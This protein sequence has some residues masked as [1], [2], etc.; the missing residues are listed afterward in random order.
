MKTRILDLIDFEKVDTLLEGFNQS[1]GFVT[2]ILDL[3]GNVLSKS[4]WR[5]VC[6][7]FHRIHPETA[8]RCTISDTVLAGQMTTD[9]KYHFYKCLNGLVDVAVPIVIKGEHIANLFSGQFFFEEPNLQFFREQA[10]K[11]G[12]DEEIYVDAMLKVP[13]IAEEKVKV[14]MEFLLN[15]TQLISEMTFNKIKQ[16]ELNEQL[17]KSEERYRLVLENSLDAILLTSPD[18]KILSAN[19][20]AC[21]I[22]QRTEEEICSLSREGIVDYTDPRLPHLLEE[23]NRTGKAKGE[24]FMLRKD[25]TKFPV[26]LSTS[27]FN[28]QNGVLLTSMI[29]RDISERYKSEI[30]LKL[31]EEKF[32][33]AFHNSPDA[34][35]I[36][37]VS[38]GKIID[39]NETFLKLSGYER[40]FAIGNSTLLLNLWNSPND[41]KTYITLLKKQR[42]VKD[43]ESKFITSSGEVRDFLVSG[44]FFTINGENCIL[45]IL[46]DITEQKLAEET[47][48][49]NEQ[50]LRLFV[51]HSPAAIAMFDRDMRYIVASRRYLSDYDL[52][53]RDIIGRS[54]YDIFPEMP[55]EWKNIHQHCLKGAIEKSDN[56]PFPRASGK[57]DWIRWEIHPWFEKNDEI[58][59][60]IL[61]SEVITESKLSENKLKETHQ[62]LVNILENMTDGFVS[63]DND[64]NYTYMNKYAGEI[65]GRVPEEMIGKHIWTEFPEGIGQPFHLAY[66]KAKSEKIPIQFHEYYPPYKKWFENRIYPS[67]D[68]I[69]VF[70]QDI[71]E[72]KLAQDKLKDSQTYNRMLFEQSPIGLAL[73]N[74]DGKLIDVNP[75][76]AAIMGRTVDQCKQL[77]YWEITPEKYAP[78][79]KKQL[80]TLAKTGIYG[81]YEKEYIHKNGHLVPVRLQGLIF[82]RNGEKY[83]WS[84]VEDITEIKK[85]NEALIENRQIIKDERDFSNALLDGLPGILYFYDSNLNFQRWNKNFEKISG[86]SSE[87]IAQMSPMDLFSDDEKDLLK[88]KISTVFSEGYADVEAHFLTKNGNRILYFFTGL[89]INFNNKDC[90]IG[91]GIDISSLKHAEEEIKKLNAE[92]EFKVDLRTAQLE[93]SNK[94]LEAF[95]YSVSHDLR[96]PLRHINGYVNLLNDRFKDELPEKA[97]HYLETVT[98]AA[99]QMGMLIDDL[100]QFSRTGRQEVHQTITDMNVLINEALE[101]IKPDIENRKINW[102]IQ[103]LPEVFG[104]YALLKQ[105][106]INLIDNAVK[107]TRNEAF[108]EISVGCTENQENFVF[109]VRDNGVGFDM[110]YAHKLFGVFQRL[111]AQSEFEGTGIGLANVQRIIHKHNG[112][113]WAEAEPKI[114]ATFFFSLPKNKGDL[115]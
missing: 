94:E 38:D 36:T 84:S 91:V 68:G 92:L 35:T 1:T 55:E 28:D 64:W 31:S 75:K 5:Q 53:E 70:F 22:F 25:G 111:H 33:K 54:H 115:I 114:G 82:E 101:K 48:H 34:I 41:R 17:K 99:T 69:S 49:R 32:N 2:A 50:V 113:V 11:Y 6:T 74:M 76:Y 106:W 109:F 65:F 110:K 42:S 13:V 37:R 52:G 47:I 89:K 107:Y 98:N 46:R 66:E 15:M 10:K 83:I 3:E 102:K 40:D 87:E 4:G 57:L 79:E 71:T 58:G 18:G 19:R 43:F 30:A 51:E 78:M 112:Q 95:S 27:V 96:A 45:G 104:D 73:A 7:E 29:I 44:E 61:F 86:Y 67:N 93:A 108:A 26:E 9:K 14:A 72:I 16:S 62:K 100:L 24:L 90:L 12:F 105:V 60:V 39:V 63:L 56:D 59:G 81:P 88:D 23:R 85:S 21:S 80:E 97:R 103:E 77:T 20:A 8:K